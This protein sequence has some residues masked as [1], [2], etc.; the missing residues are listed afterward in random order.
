[1]T[2]E[3]ETINKLYLELSQLATA[4]TA[5]EIE[6]AKS[7]ATRDGKIIAEIIL[8]ADDGEMAVICS[9][10]SK[11]P[12]QGVTNFRIRYEDGAE[13]FVSIRVEEI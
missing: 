7:S 5:R 4:K 8:M 2:M 11:N 10:I 1:M 3:L 6:L 9:D 13:Y 12:A